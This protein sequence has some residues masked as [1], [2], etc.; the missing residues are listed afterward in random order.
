MKSSSD[1]L[2]PLLKRKPKRGASM[3][4]NQIPLLAAGVCLVTGLVVAAL[5]YAT[6]GTAL[7]WPVAG[8]LFLISCSCPVK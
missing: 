7:S 3:D 1:L 4:R 2:T 8:L 5:G 6:Q